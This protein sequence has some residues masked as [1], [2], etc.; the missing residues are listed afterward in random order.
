MFGRRYFSGFSS[1][2]TERIS[3]FQYNPQKNKA[4]FSKVQRLTPDLVMT[5]GEIPLASLVAK[6]PSTPFIVGDYYSTDIGNRANVVMM[7]SQL[8]VGT[9]LNLAFSLFP[10]R[11][12]IG[13]MY[14]PKFSQT[15]LDSLVSTA[16]KKGIQVASIKV[17]SPRD[18]RSYI[19]AFSGKTDLYYYIRDNTTSDPQALKLIYEFMEQ[20][21]IPVISLDPAHIEKGAL[22][23]V[24]VD[25]VELGEQ[26][27]NVARVILKEGKIPQM[28]VQLHPSELTIS[29]SIG[30]ASRF[31]IGSDALFAFLQKTIK[32]G[33]SVRVEP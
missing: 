21:G 10:Q 13:T 2:S 29:I 23:T 8:P 30:S 27:W 26:A 9:G 24:A 11:K 15:S 31:G 33:Y 18:V 19:S 14:N 1:L 4:L 16:G 28:P 25:P 5:I 32:E 22:L 20:N 7:E 3:A 12:A 6:L 17:D